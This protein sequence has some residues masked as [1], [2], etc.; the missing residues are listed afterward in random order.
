DTPRVRRRLHCVTL[1]KP[2]STKNSGMICTNQV[3]AAKPPQPS[4]AFS[5]SGAP[6]AML[7]P[8]MKECRATT[9]TRHH[10]RATS[11]EASRAVRVLGVL[12]TGAGDAGALVA[13]RR[14]PVVGSMSVVMIRALLALSRVARAW[15]RGRGR[16]ITLR[17]RRHPYRGR[18]RR[19]RHSPRAGDEPGD[20]LA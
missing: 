9:T 16:H 13:V 7:T 10:A 14:A 12:R 3:S 2:P 20:R 5:S 6:P 4:M 18:G 8:T 15:C 11:I 1:E 17:V 19:R